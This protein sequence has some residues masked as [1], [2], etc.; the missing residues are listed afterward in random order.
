[1]T[2]NLQ[3]GRAGRPWEDLKLGQ[4]LCGGEANI[5]SPCAAEQKTACAMQAVDKNDQSLREDCT[6][7]KPSHPILA[8]HIHDK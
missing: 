2:R 7:H 1:M 3:A 6:S 4:G 5:V 8:G